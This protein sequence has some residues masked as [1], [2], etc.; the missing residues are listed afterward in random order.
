GCK[1]GSSTPCIAGENF[2]FKVETFGYTIQPS[3]DSFAWKFGDGG[4]AGGQTSAHAYEAGNFNVELKVTNNAGSVTTTAPLTVGAGT[5]NSPSTDIKLTWLGLSSGCDQTKTCTPGER[6]R[7]FLSSASGYQLQTCD[8]VSWDFGDGQTSNTKATLIEHTYASNGPFLVG[9]AVANSKGTVTD[10]KT[11]SF[12][13]LP[14]PVVSIEASGNSG[15]PGDTLSFVGTAQS[16]STLTGHLWRVSRVVGGSN[17]VVR[18]VAN[19]GSISHMFDVE[20]DYRVEYTAS[21]AGGS[22]DPAVANVKISNANQ[23]AFLL[24]VVAHLD[25]QNDTKWR[26]DLQIYNTDPANAPISLEFEFRGG[27]TQF[28]KTI[29]LSASTMVYEDFLS[30]LVAPFALDDAGPVIVRGSGASLPQMWTRTYTVDASGIGSYGQLIP[31]VRLDT[32]PQSSEAP[33][34]YVVPGLEISS[35]YRTNLGLVNPSNQTVQATVTVADDSMLG[36]PIGQFTIDIGPYALTQIGNLADR[37]TQL[38][39]GKPFSIRIATVGNASL[40]VY[41][42]MIDQTSNDPVY[43][44]GI[45]E[46]T[47]AGAEKRIQV[48]PGAGHIVQGNDTWRSDVVVYNADTVPVRFNLSYFD[49]AGQKVA[50]AVE[51]AL[52]PG[53]FM[54]VEDVLRWPLLDKTPP[55]SFGMI[56]IETIGTGIVRYPIVLER[57][58]KDRGELGTF[59]QGIPGISPDRPN[60]ELG[61]PAFIAGVRSD[62]SFYTNLGL[63]AVGNEPS[64]VKVSLLDGTSGLVVGTWEY[65]PAGASA[66]VAIAPNQSII[67]ANII[68]AL[69]PTAT[70]GTLKIEVMEGG[71]VWAY[72]SVIAAADPSCNCTLPNHTFDPEYIPAVR[73]G[74]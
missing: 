68:R 16:S 32:S 35:R 19:E 9:I 39:D 30:V 61:K 1:A 62:T 71:P 37:V 6:I 74:D 2:S 73:S 57:T 72:A 3:C 7:F 43:I 56:K 17:Q 48:V 52:G 70:Q 38:R 12:V 41:G 23:F 66:P 54:R 10:A 67:A 25:G 22:S 27:S 34:S 45:H 69:S 58:Y 55:D 46:S 15:K 36:F 20:G 47:Q 60:V 63:V 31:A 33:G 65:V 8:A 29:V 49:S 21:N 42:S 24:P 5:C 14:K 51:Q 26:T 4:T 59:G 44:P 64:K 28:T 18:T 53:A 40:V 50:E 11:L 13:S